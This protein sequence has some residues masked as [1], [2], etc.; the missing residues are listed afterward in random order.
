MKKKA[1]PISP[2]DVIKLKGKNIPQEVIEVFNTLIAKHWNGRSAILMQEEVIKEILKSFKAADKPMTR[3]IL[4]E[5][6]YLEIDDLFRKRGWKVE[7]DKP[8]YNE[9]YEAS[10]TFSKR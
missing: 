4:F 1:E 6:N 5:E 2:D 7:Y 9:S 3:S 10:W 8:G